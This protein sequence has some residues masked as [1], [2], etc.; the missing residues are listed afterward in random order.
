MA[1]SRLCTL[2]LLCL[3]HQWEVWERKYQHFDIFKKQTCVK[4]RKKLGSA[5]SSRPCNLMQDKHL[6]LGFWGFFFSPSFSNWAIPFGLRMAKFVFW[7]L[8]PWRPRRMGRRS[9]SC[10]LLYLAAGPGVMKLEVEQGT[11]Q[12]IPPQASLLTYWGLVCF[13]WMLS[14]F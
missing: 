2:V 13:A 12:G 4:R 11:P 1:A 6:H 5:E 8:L 9:A 10:Y 14:L 7:R 3:S